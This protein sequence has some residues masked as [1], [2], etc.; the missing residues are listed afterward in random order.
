MRCLHASLGGARRAIAGAHPRP[1]LPRSVAPSRVCPWPGRTAQTLRVPRGKRS[2]WPR[3]AHDAAG[4]RLRS[5]R[6]VDGSCK[7][8]T[9]IGEGPFGSR[10]VREGDG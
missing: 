1:C 7:V 8:G 4:Q 10:L 6:R 2:L 5:R 3:P 9:S